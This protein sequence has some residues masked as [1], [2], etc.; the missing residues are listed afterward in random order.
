LW[1]IARGE[2]AAHRQAG[3]PILGIG[4]NQARA[5]LFKALRL[6][7]LLVEAFEAIEGEVGAFGRTRQQSV[8]RRFGAL[9]IAFEESHV[10]E[11]QV[12]GRRVGILFD[13]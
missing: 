1:L 9:E 4:G 8:P 13:R 7:E 3:A 10:A 5:S 12:R 11:V 6:A 2:V